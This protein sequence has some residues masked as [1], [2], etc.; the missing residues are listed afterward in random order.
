MGSRAQCL[1]NRAGRLL[2]PSG[3]R[4]DP[5]CK[6]LTSTGTGGAG[7]R[8]DFAQ[9]LGDAGH[10]SREGCQRRLGPLA[11]PAG[12]AVGSVGHTLT[13]VPQPILHASQ[14]RG[15]ASQGLGDGRHFVAGAALEA[16][17]KGIQH[18]LDTVFRSRIQAGCQLLQR[19]G[20]RPDMLAEA[21]VERRVQRGTDTDGQLVGEGLH[22]RGLGL[23]KLIRLLLKR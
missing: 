7:L 17:Q 9:C 14:G 2:E 4:L 5:R 10:L 18:S 6:F 15:E 16:F 3:R 19:L 8:G 21:L 22:L 1:G 11:H 13:G 12:H 20:E 23:E